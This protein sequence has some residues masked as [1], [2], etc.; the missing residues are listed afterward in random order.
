MTPRCEKT[1]ILTASQRKFWPLNPD[2]G[3]IVIEDIAHALSNKCRFTGH[4]KTFYS[5]AQHSVLVARNC[6]DQRWGLL[7]D[8]AE[9]YLPDVAKPIKNYLEGFQAIESKI[10]RCVAYR[11]G[12]PEEI[13]EE[14]GIVDQRMCLTEM[15]DLMDGASR[16]EAYDLKIVPWSPKVARDNFIQ[17]FRTIF[18]TNHA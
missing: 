7:H 5:V 14:I 3:D 1:Y 8:A 10:L 13:P 16:F 12:L 15:R 2:W 9:A 18:R 4:T 11:F 6:I 17:A